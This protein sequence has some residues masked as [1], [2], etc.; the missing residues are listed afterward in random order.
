[1][2]WQAT[3]FERDRLI[4]FRGLTREIKPGL[5]GDREDWIEPGQEWGGRSFEEWMA[6]LRARG[7]SVTIGFDSTRGWVERE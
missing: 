5:L 7:G 3:L 4:T 6:F 2:D 1:M